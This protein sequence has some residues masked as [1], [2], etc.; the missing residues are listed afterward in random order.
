MAPIGSVGF[1][2]WVMDE[3]IFFDNIVVT[4]DAKEAETLR[5][6]WTERNELEKATEEAEKEKQRKEEVKDHSGFL[7]QMLDNAFLH[8]LL[9]VLEPLVD[10]IEQQGQIFYVFVA[11]MASLILSTLL[12]RCLRS[13]KKIDDKVAKQKKEDISE[14]DDPPKD[15]PKN[16]DEPSTSGTRPDEEEDDQKETP[17][18]TRSR[19]SN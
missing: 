1:E 10:F 9:P 3:N 2:L 5:E 19:R 8:P 7:R 12:R 15:P 16:E 11:I 18:A 6:K 4:R 13:T 14:P 17:K